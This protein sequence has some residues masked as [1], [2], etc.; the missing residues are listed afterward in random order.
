MNV[1]KNP[2]SVEARCHEMADELGDL[3]E[4]IK[5]EK[6][7]PAGHAGYYLSILVKV[8]NNKNEMY[9]LAAALI[10]AGAK[11]REVAL[12]LDAAVS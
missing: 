11:G 4:I 7:I 12:A 6:A 5:K 1:K 8:G 3:V 10:L 2:A 9:M